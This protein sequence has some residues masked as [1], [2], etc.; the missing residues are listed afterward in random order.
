MLDFVK[1]STFSRRLVKL[2]SDERYKDLQAALINNPKL[3]VVIGGTGGA[4]KVRWSPEGKGKSGGVRVIYYL[5]EKEARCYMLIIYGKGERDSL[6][7]AQKS[8]LKKYIKDHLA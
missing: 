1:A 6:T 7:D 5:N 8:T 4:R 3:G 2:L